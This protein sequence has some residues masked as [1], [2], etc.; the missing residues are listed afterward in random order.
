MEKPVCVCCLKEFEPDGSPLI[1]GVFLKQSRP[2]GVCPTCRKNGKPPIISLDHVP[3]EQLL[4][5]AAG[6]VH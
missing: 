2:A 1:G 6:T 3:Q 5:Q 4:V